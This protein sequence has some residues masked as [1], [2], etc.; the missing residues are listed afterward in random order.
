MNLPAALTFNCRWDILKRVELS[1]SWPS[2]LDNIIPLKLVAVGRLV[3]VEEKQ[4]AI[5]IEQYTFKTSRS[6]AQ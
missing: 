2:R 3:R 5:T 6:V 4:A 1:V